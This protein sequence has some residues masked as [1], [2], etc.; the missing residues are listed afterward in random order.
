MGKL[1]SGILY[2]RHIDMRA[3]RVLITVLCVSMAS[4]SAT[5]QSIKKLEF[6]LDT[7]TE[8]VGEL[9]PTLTFSIEEPSEKLGWARI[10]WGK[11]RLSNKTGKVKYA[12]AAVALFGKDGALLTAGGSAY[13]KAD[14]IRHRITTTKR[15]G[16]AIAGYRVEDISY[17]SVR[18]IESDTP[19]LQYHPNAK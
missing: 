2:R 7:K 14:G 15:I 19:L 17:A 6:Q 3:T 18:Y 4:T 16:L 11:V 9:N 8:L 12:Y 1:G 13:S 10:L 5:A